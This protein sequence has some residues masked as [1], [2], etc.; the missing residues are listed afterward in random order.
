MI[1][2]VWGPTREIPVTDVKPGMWVYCYLGVWRCV[3]AVTGPTKVL[4]NYEY[5]VHQVAIEWVGISSYGNNWL[6]T[7]KVLVRG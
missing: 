6:A 5:R 4:G 7:D 1:R 2:L 3:R